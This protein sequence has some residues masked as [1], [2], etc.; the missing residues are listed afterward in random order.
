MAPTDNT[1]GLADLIAQ[2]KKELLTVAPGNSK[3]KTAPMLFVES[4]ELELQI[5]VERSANGGVN[6]G[7]M[8]IGGIEAGGGVSRQD[9]HTVKVNLASLFD[10]ERLME[11]YQTLH[12]DQVPQ[13]IKASLEGLFKGDDENLD[14]GVL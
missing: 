5:T 13:T 6:I 8:S 4:V 1:I 3:D 11:F 7:V 9:V 12:P 10:K 14:A 2:V